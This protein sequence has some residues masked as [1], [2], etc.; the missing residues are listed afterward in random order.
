MFHLIKNKI[1]HNITKI[2]HVRFLVTALL[3]TVLTFQ[4]RIEYINLSEIE[5]KMY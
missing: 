1:Q 4:K 5:T 2:L 3:T